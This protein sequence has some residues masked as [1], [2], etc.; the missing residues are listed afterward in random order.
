MITNLT[1]GAFSTQNIRPRGLSSS[2]I[3][4]FDFIMN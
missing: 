2:V 1:V 4:G 3:A